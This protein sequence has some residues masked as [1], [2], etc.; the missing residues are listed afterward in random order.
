MIGQL[1]MFGQNIWLLIGILF[2][3]LFGAVL[4]IAAWTGVKVWLFRRDQ[5]RGK[6]EAEQSK[7]D[8]D[9][10]P[11]PPS[12]PGICQQCGKVRDKVYHLP[13]GDRLCAACYQTERRT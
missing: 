1:E 11:L 4:L 9:G 3:V 7:S 12:S 8:A 6:I 13:S 2:F 10:G 5:A